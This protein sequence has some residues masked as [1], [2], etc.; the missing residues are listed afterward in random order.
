MSVKQIRE[1]Q[2]TWIPGVR[3]RDLP[4]PLPSRIR[5]FCRADELGIEAQ[6]LVG[7]IHLGNGDTLQI[8]PKVG[9]ANFLRMLFRSL[10]SQVD[11]NRQFRDLVPYGVE[12]AESVAVLAA[13][14]LV[15]AADTVLRG[16]PST[17]RLR[18][19]KRV[20]SA[21]G[22]VLPAPTALA[23]ARHEPDPVVTRMRTRSHDTSENRV[24]L[25]ALKMAASLLR[26]PERRE[27][28][29]TQDRWERRV[30]H[31]RMR[32]DDIL[33]TRQRIARSWYAGPRGYY[34]PAVT[35]ALVLLGSLG[36]TL[37][38]EATLE[39]EAF[40]LDSADVFEEYVRR[41]IA[42]HYGRV[43]CI[44]SKGGSV[45][46]TLYQ[47]GSF[48]IAPDVVIERQ[49]TILLVGDAKY[50]EPT[51]D[52]HYQMLSYL[53]TMGADLGVLLTPNG[54]GGR[55]QLSCH[56]TYER[57]TTIVADLPVNDLDATEDF[58]ADVVDRC[59]VLA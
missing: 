42:D 25:H 16:G 40:L 49:A 12:D 31:E 5:L 52:D 35:L 32:L 2:P 37:S 13:R 24:I 29:E 4:H 1:G 11:F 43:G 7:S 3:L 46:R 45:S 26:S 47:D 23:L 17:S 19:V 20:S 51:S 54:R 55:P 58:L 38:K 57:F 28:L 36:M 10:A 50:K 14:Q 56:K 30:C 44:V 22:Q 33:L 6:G 53:M 59:Q 9:E 39:G 18:V 41:V 48:G 21:G 27:A 34:S 15:R 8:L